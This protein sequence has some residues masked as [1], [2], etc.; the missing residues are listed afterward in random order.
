MT[1]R[2]VWYI[3]LSNDGKIGIGECAPLPGLSLDSFDQIDSKLDE[4]CQNP[5]QFLT[6]FSLLS[7]F[8]SLRFG[9]EMAALDLNNDGGQN[10]YNDFK[11]IDINGLIWMGNLDFM[12]HQV[13]KKLEEGWKCIKMKIGALDFDKE[14]EILKSIRNRFGENSLEL[15]MD[16]NGAFKKDDVIEKLNRLA[17]FD[18]HSIEQP[19]QTGQ[20]DLL[21]ELCQTSLVPIALDEELI[22]L[23]HE[24]GRTEMLEKVQPQYLVLKP[25]LLGGFSESEKWVE[26][27]KQQNIGWWITSA[28]ESNIGL[29]A[30]AQ[31]TSKMNPDGFQGLG[32]GQLFTN[33]IPSH[34]KVKSGILLQDDSPIWGEVKQ[35]ISDWYSPNNEMMLQTSGSTGKPKSIKVKKEWMKNSAQLTGKT[36]EL[37]EGDSTLLCMPMKYVAGKMMVVR[38]LA[39]GLDLKVVEPSSSPLKGLNKPIDFAA[40][41]PLQLEKSLN[42]LDK[43]KTLIVGG[44]QVNPAL[45]DKLRDISTQVYETYSMTETLTHVAIKPLNGPNKQ[46]VFQALDGVQFEIDERDC[47]V[48]HAPMLNPNPVLTNDLVALI[49]ETSFRWL[50]RYDNVINSGGIKIIP[51]KVEAKL[52]EANPN[53]LFFIGGMPDDT[54]GEKLV[55]FVEGEEIDISF[56]CLDKF[57]RPKEVCFLPKFIKT[58]SG[59]INR[60]RSVHLISK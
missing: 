47:L 9:L 35:F 13:E 40:M 4:I 12:M 38:A 8:P 44:G 56:E 11:S 46:D 15:R 39:L 18:L 27:A 17:E 54:M 5:N 25:S 3:T 10:Y 26:L 20:W 42:Q 41:V 31:W 2:D 55:L 19:I 23:V 22:P 37:K 50:G 36:F 1:S 51:E 59:K 60:K 32:T 43:V 33:N 30:I 34:L 49:D 16:A 48:I 58:A 21:S 6:N 57:T 29:N 28:L 14:L 7:D 45:V 24:K 53:V 52:T